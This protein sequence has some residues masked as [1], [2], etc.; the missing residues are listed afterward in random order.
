MFGR[1][2]LTHQPQHLGAEPAAARLGREHDRA[3][4]D[5]AGLGFV[6]EDLDEAEE[7]GALPPAASSKVI[8]HL[9]FGDV[10]R[11][12]YYGSDA[13]RSPTTRYRA[14]GSPPYEG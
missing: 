11:G 7:V 10:G 5:R 14:P 9:L 4:R 3:Q 13:Q 1:E 6:R 8:C 12:L 2:A